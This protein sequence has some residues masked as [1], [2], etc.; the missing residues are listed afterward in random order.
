MKVLLFGILADATK[1]SEIE[2]QAHDMDALKKNLLTQFPVLNEYRF[3]FAVNK[4]KI[5]KNILLN[6]DDEIALLPP[7]AG[8]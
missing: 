3:Q 4:E 5:E 2:I 7:F 6:D 8:G 1:K